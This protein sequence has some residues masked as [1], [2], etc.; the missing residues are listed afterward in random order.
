MKRI[1]V[2]PVLLL[3]LAVVFHGFPGNASA[4]E[5]KNRPVMQGEKDDSRSVELPEK[6]IIK[7]IRV[8]PIRRSVLTRKNRG[9]EDIEIFYKELIVVF[10]FF[11][12]D[13][14]DE[15]Q[16]KYWYILEGFDLE[17]RQVQGSLPSVIYSRLQPG[18]YVFRV[19]R[20]LL[21]EEEITNTV[22]ESVKLIITPPFWGTWWFRLSV[23][24]LVIGL[25][26]TFF[27]LKLRREK[28]IRQHELK[29]SQMQSQLTRAELK[30]LKA[31]LHPHFL[32]NT[33]N[34]ISSLMHENVEAADNVITRLGDLLRLMFSH[35]GQKMVRLKDEIEFITIYLELHQVRFQDKL[36]VTLDIAGDTL[37]ALVPNFL[38]QPLVENA[39]QHGISKD[40][41]DNKILVR[42]QK[43]D[44]HLCLLIRD[45]GPG[46][47]QLETGDFINIKGGFG[48]KNTL[49]RL[50]IRYEADFKF[51]LE[52]SPEGGLIVLIEIPYNSNQGDE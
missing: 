11:H 26:Y 22:E 34:V 12:W 41:S 40:K 44:N 37:E 8:G 47:P 31:Q 14:Y 3:F 23:L 32:F 38:L 21:K 18:S 16:V 1:L 13:L 35:S 52:N 50:K 15:R 39:V 28:K 6:Q 36:A 30:A 20:L 24:L 48:L 25:L 17:W 33:L 46:I 2:L 19:K 7:N 43:K 27:K 10:E 42:S 49:E 4:Q 45:N 29:I 5:A 9:I 51:K